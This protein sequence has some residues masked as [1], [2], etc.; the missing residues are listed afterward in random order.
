MN[1]Q[2]TI[3][4]DFTKGGVVKQLLI[5]TLPLF[6]SNLLQM[7]YNMVDMMVVGNVTG[8]VGLSAVSV[9]GDVSNFLTFIAIGFSGAGQVIISQYIGAGQREKVGRFIGNMALFL[10]IVAIALTVLGI[11][12]NEAILGWMNTPRASWDD[13][14]DYA[15]TCAAGLVFIYGYNVTSAILRGI[16]DSKR[17]FIFISIAAVLNTVL[18]I[19]FVR[20]LHMRAFGAALATVISQAVSFIVSTI[21]LYR[22]RHALGFSIDRG[23]FKLDVQ[24]MKPLVELGVPMAIK[25]SSIQ[26]SKLFVN[27]WINSY[28]VTV[29]AVSG[30]GHK[31]SNVANLVSNALATAG[32]SMVGQNIGAEKY[33]RVSGII[34]SINLVA[35]AFSILTTAAIILFPE[36]IFRVF[37]T[38][39]DSIRQV[40]LEFVPPACVMFLGSASRSSMNALINGS[41]N[42]KVNFAVAVM[43][44][45][46]MR[47]G[48][49]LLMGLALDMGYVG[50]WYGDSIAGFT[51]GVIGTAYY[52]SGKWKT[53][54][55]VIQS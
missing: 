34:K 31:L 54:K 37:T 44:G 19:L 18:D 10:L 12:L 27:S 6:L 39:F 45:I 20:Y 24:M 43:D 11:G 3:M 30:V 8:Q 42:Y 14:K 48:L 17:P 38:D 46:I 7:V 50:F 52:I 25:Q 55:Y 22:R 1:G 53:R 26:F 28:G 23:C 33:K 47:I 40:A 41:G 49:A 13:A 16:G 15:V 35:G 2:R 5:F 51:P 9:G 21:Y 36:E 29:S 4:R 32:A